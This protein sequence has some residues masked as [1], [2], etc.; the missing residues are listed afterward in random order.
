MSDA[1]EADPPELEASKPTR[2]PVIGYAALALAAAVAIAVGGYL[3]TTSG[4]GN[5]D[6][7]QFGVPISSLPGAPTA[8]P[9]TG[10]LQPNRPDLNTP[11]PDFALIDARDEKLIRRLSDYRGKAVVLNWFASWCGPCKEEIPE[12]QKAQ[13]VLGDQLVIL[14]VDYLESA[15]KA[16]GI[17]DQ[18]GGTYPAV[19]DSNG[20]V[21]DHYRVKYLPTTYFIDRDGVVRDMHTG[22]ITAN[23]LPGFLAKIGLSYTAP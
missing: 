22:Q 9:G 2:S 21:A 16:T 17:L 1:P 23:A 5:N 8:A 3:V 20:S 6:G 4:N 19:L 13:E 10:V 12:F 14:G 18:F 11:A 7:A 15:G